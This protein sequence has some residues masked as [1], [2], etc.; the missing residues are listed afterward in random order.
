MD[1]RQVC[2]AATWVGVTSLVSPELLVEVEATAIVK[3]DA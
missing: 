2:P 1:K 3:D